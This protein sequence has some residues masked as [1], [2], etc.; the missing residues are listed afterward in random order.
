MRKALSCRACVAPYP[1]DIVSLYELRATRR[2]VALR[3]DIKLLESS[4][5][6]VQ[7]DK[8]NQRRLPVQVQ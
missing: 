3:E 4:S 8:L 6:S 5:N 2:T 7:R 1:K